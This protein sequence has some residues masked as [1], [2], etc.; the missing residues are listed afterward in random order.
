M[1]RP[2]ALLLTLALPLAACTVSGVDTSYRSSSGY[3][4]G[5]VQQAPPPTPV[6]QQQPYP[7]TYAQP[8][9]PQADTSAA[10]SV[11]NVEASL[12][13]TYS[14]AERYDGLRDLQGDLRTLGRQINNVQDLIRRGE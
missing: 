7:G 5:Y 13:R 9:Y 1:I 6:Y 2:T 11:D 10:T 12:R 4:G 14:A 3:D 8:G